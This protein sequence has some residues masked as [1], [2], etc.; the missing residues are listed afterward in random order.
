MELVTTFGESDLNRMFTRLPSY[1]EEYRELFGELAQNHS[2]Y[3]VAGS[4]LQRVR[5]QYYNMGHL[6]TLDGQVW[7]QPKLHLFSAERFGNTTP[8]ASLTVIQTEK[9]K[10]SMLIC[11][12]LE[13][14]EAARLATLQGAEILFSPSA[15]LDEYGYWRVRHCAHAR[16]IENQVYVVHC[17]LVGAVDIAGLSFSDRS[18]IL[19]PCDRGYPSRGVIAEGPMDQEVIVTGEADLDLLYS[20]RENGASAHPEG[21]EG[22]SVAGSL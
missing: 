9:A 16:C 22:G 17:S 10:V 5:E 4:H 13:L 2:V 12:N 7:Q 6:F 3:I 21:P 19:G 14:P 15:T 11:Y 8:G 20:V 18:S 1:T